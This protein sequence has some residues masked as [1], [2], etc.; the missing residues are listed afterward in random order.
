MPRPL[1]T[2]THTHTHTWPALRISRGLWEYRSRLRHIGVSLAFRGGAPPWMPHSLST[3][4]K[5]LAQVGP[6]RCCLLG[7]WNFEW[8][9]TEISASLEQKEVDGSALERK[10]CDVLLWG[11]L[12]LPI[13]DNSWLSNL[14]L[15]YPMTL[16][17]FIPCF[18]HS[19]PFF[20][21][22]SWPELVSKACSQISQLIK[23]I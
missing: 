18:P 13:C 17:T 21:P 2:L 14:V 22:S 20:F 16:L 6:I 15:N 1:D 7:I 19:P 3:C 10:S 4:G 11:P 12:R 9:S 5:C 8:R 23:A